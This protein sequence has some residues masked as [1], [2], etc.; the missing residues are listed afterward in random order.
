MK[1]IAKAFRHSNSVQIVIPKQL[2]QDMNWG[3]NTHFVINKISETEISI[4]SIDDAF[5]V[6][7]NRK[8]NIINKGREINDKAM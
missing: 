8:N 4:R 5:I 6:P 7:M 1:W 2:V 3:F